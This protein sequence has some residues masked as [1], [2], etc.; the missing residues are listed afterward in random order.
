MKRPYQIESQRAVKR[1]EE[2]AADGNP[3]VQMVL[4]MAEMVG[5][6]RQGV[7]EL[8]RQAGLRIIELLMEEEVRKLAGERSQPQQELLADRVFENDRQRPE[9]E[10]V[11][12]GS[13]P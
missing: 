9:L 3:A 8:I 6:L 5:W 4:P 10:Y 12:L 7:G 2:M 11:R 13:N 1:L